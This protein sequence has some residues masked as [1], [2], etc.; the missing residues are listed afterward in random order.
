M[1]EADIIQGYVRGSERRTLLFQD[2]HDAELETKIIFGK[3]APGAGGSAKNTKAKVKAKAEPRAR[4]V[5]VDTM[6]GDTRVAECLFQPIEEGFVMKAFLFVVVL[7]LVGIAGLGFY[8]GWFHLSSDTDRADHK[9]NTT[10]TVDEDKIREDKEKVQE[11]ARPAK[12][13]TG[14]AIEQS[15]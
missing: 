12:E 6:D 8:R 7:L 15:K 1:E 11:F 10:F 5:I 4:E 3:Y 14:K 13:K 9:V 2:L